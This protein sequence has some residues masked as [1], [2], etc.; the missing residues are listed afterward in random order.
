[1]KAA[2]YARYSSE[3]QSEK[4][5][6]D[7]I[8]VCRNYCK[9]HE[10]TIN[11]EHI[12]IDEAIS[13]SLIN[14]PGLQALEKA[15]ENKEFEAVMVDDLSRL[16]RSNHQMLT[17][18]LKF[19]YYQVKLIS[20]SDGIITDDENSKLGIQMRGLINELYLDDLRK[21][22]LR[23]LEGQKLRGFSAGE[24]V[25]G[26]YT[27]PVGELK[28]NRKGQAKYEGM[29]HKINPDEAEIV[30]RIFKEFAEGKSIHKIATQLNEEKIPTKKNMRG[31][32]N[33]STASRILKNEKYIG[34]WNWRKSKVVRDPMTGKKKKFARPEKD[35]IP[36]YREDLIIID[37]ELWEKAQKR[38]HELKGT[39]P[40][41][42]KK[43]GFYQQKSYIHTSPN[44]LLS[45]LMKCQSCGGAIVLLSGKGGGYYGCYNSRRKTCANMLLIPRKKIEEIIITELKDKILTVDNL[46]YVYQKVE[47]LAGEGFNEVPELVKKKKAQYEKIQQEIQNYLNFI[48]VGN[49]SKAVSEALTDAEKRNDELKQEVESLEF[50]KENSFKAPPKEWI[51]HRLEN[52]RETLNKNTVFSSIALKELLAPINLEPVLTKENDF[53]QLFSGDE[54]NFKPYYVA[55]TKI[56]TL[57]LL[58]E[59]QNSGTVPSGDSPCGTNSSNWYHWRKE[60]DS[61][62]RDLTAWT[63][64]RRL[65]STTLPSFPL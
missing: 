49:L 20:V 35:I 38:W 22:T 9:E 37:K 14:R 31:G 63:L 5:I 48:M 29:V 60:Q 4:S 42:K 59:K 57:A 18:V 43:R 51:N 47:R 55:H 27:K 16:S 1:M 32:W 15:A 21:K 19:N 2:I 39:W 62:L 7:Q 45:G 8:R 36:I 34:T 3:N 41:S 40:V 11:D 44:H 30:K 56:Q 46:E 6:D 58:D 65:D 33:I 61:N 50:Q 10:I 54:R 28:L 24:K 52:L 26:Y 12:Y 13:G 17:L 25:Y 64:S 23:G 53:Y